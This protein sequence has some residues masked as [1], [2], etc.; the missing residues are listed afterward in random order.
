MRKIGRIYTDYILEISPRWRRYNKFNRFSELLLNQL[1]DELSR[2]KKEHNAYMIISP[3]QPVNG[4]NFMQIR[5]D[6]D[7]Y[8]MEYSLLQNNKNV[9]YCKNV[10]ELDEA[11]KVLFD[12]LNLGIVPDSDEWA[13]FDT[14]E[15]GE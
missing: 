12:F 1:F 4:C 15:C 2:A 5:N 6:D 7:Y 8:R 11:R 13:Y 10:T 14:F 3:L 9:L